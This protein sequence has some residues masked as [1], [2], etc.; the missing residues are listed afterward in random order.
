VLRRPSGLKQKCETVSGDGRIVQEVEVLLEAWLRRSPSKSPGR[1]PDT[2]SALRSWAMAAS[3]SSRMALAMGLSLNAMCKLSPSRECGAAC[4]GVT[5]GS[6]GAED[7]RARAVL[8]IRSW[9]CPSG[10]PLIQQQTLWSRR[11]ARPR[12]PTFS[13]FVSSRCHS[14][15]CKKKKKYYV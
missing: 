13:V 5:T 14:N 3:S 15:H 10:E 1:R 7:V 11:S 12:C 4:S 8:R 6:T 2:F 9:T